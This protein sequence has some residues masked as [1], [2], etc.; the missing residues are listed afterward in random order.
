MKTIRVRGSIKSRKQHNLCTYAF[1]WINLEESKARRERMQKQFEER[2]IRNHRIVAIN[3]MREKLS[4]FLGFPEARARAHKAEIATTLSHLKA[5]HAFVRSGEAVGIICEDDMVFDYESKWPY[6]ISSVIENAPKDWEILQMSITLRSEPGWTWFKEQNQRYH[7]RQFFWYSAL[8]YA[9]T[10][11]RALELMQEYEIPTDAGSIFSCKLKGN[12]KKLQSEW[13][14]LGTGSNRY[15]LYPPAFTYP[16]NNTSFIHS[17]H[18]KMHN[19]ARLMSDQAYS[20]L[21]KLS[22][23]VD[24]LH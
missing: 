2:N 10:R 8:T 20:D 1:F 3:G 5:I 23:T 17:H 21:Q 11:K 18:L 24:N 9:I 6:T 14:V 22:D 7:T 15:T 12:P 13:I 4:T 19:E 16:L